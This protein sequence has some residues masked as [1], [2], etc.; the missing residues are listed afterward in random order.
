MQALFQ[1]NDVGRLLGDI[2]GGIDGDAHVGRVQRGRVVDAVAHEA[3][4][5]PLV[6]ERPDDPLLVRGREARKDVGASPTASA[7][8]SSVIVST[9]L[10]SRISSAFSRPRWQTLRVTSSLSPV[11]T[12]TVTPCLRERVDR[13]GRGVLRRIEEGDIALEDQVALIL[14]GMNAAACRDA[15][16]RRRARGIR[17]RST[18]SYCSINSPTSS[19]SIGK[20]SPSSSKNVQRG[21]TASGAPLVR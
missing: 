17:P 16:G 11:R 12:L 10:P 3:D 5:V 1:Q 9:L 8:S 15:C 4:D 21:K 19:G 7:S 2:D 13:L 6:L 20:I 14:L 18:R